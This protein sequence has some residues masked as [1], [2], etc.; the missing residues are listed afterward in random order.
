MTDAEEIDEDNVIVY[1]TT[2]VDS[3]GDFDANRLR[4]LAPAADHVEAHHRVTGDLLAETGDDPAAFVCPECGEGVHTKRDI[5]GTPYY[6]HYENEDCPRD[7]RD[8]LEQQ[9]QEHRKKNRTPR[10]KQALNLGIGLALSFGATA[11][12]MHW[13][14]TSEMTINGE[15]VM[16]PPATPSPYVSLGLVILLAF[17]IVL[18]LKYAPARFRRG[19]GF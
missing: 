8:A 13:M 6:R 14:P 4:S 5:D 19:G 3:A 12:V 1:A 15:S 17:T 2:T 10:W 9:R 18:A 11:A 16:V 7:T